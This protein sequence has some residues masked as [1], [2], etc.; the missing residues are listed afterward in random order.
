[1]EAP[2]RLW[3]CIVT[4]THRHR[5]VVQRQVNFSNIPIEAG[6]VPLT[7]HTLLWAFR[8]PGDGAHLKVLLAPATC[9]R[10]TKASLYA[11]LRLCTRTAKEATSSAMA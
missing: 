7:S 10:W 1:M 3:T 8:G 2:E 5:R 11:N 4:Q 9:S 6:L